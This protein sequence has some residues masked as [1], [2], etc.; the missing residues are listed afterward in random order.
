MIR[1]HIAAPQAGGLPGL[2]SEVEAEEGPGPK[3]P[4]TPKP[5][6][7]AANSK[8]VP[9]GTAAKRPA[10]APPLENAIGPK[11]LAPTASEPTVASLLALAR[12]S[13]GESPLAAH[14]MLEAVQHGS[15]R[16]MQSAC[17]PEPMSSSRWKT[18]DAAVPLD[19]MCCVGCG[20]LLHD[21]AALG[22]RRPPQQWE[23]TCQ[24]CLQPARY[25]E[26]PSH[27]LSTPEQ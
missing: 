3:T 9:S 17:F 7:A 1:A 18:A 13:G 10:C 16:Q 20:T 27:A 5:A 4:G 14:R 22:L 8:G 26:H 15:L 21:L 25:S 6:S 2:R 11:R 12:S 23:W 24:G 19:P